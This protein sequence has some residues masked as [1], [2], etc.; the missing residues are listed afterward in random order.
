MEGVKLFTNCRVLRGHRLVD[1]VVCVA[2]GRICDP[3]ERFYSHQPLVR[4]WGPIRPR[5]GRAVVA[6]EPGVVLA[7]SPVPLPVMPPRGMQ[8]H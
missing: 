6:R 4:P 3:Q 5:H 8:R 7:L 2:N 1:D